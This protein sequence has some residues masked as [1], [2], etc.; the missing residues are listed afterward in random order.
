MEAVVT[1]STGSWYELRSLAGGGTTGEAGHP[2]IFKARLRGKLRLGGSRS[3]NPVV[4][5][6]NVVCSVDDSTPGGEVWIEEI[7][8]RRN[9]IIR[10]SSN[11]SRESHIIAANIDRALVVATLFS[12]VTSPEFIDR[13][14]VT[15]EAYGIP[16][17]I[18]LNKMDLAM[19]EAPE[20]VERFTEI[21]TGAGYPVIHA[22]AVTGQGVD[23]VRELLKGRTTLVSGNS[24]VGKSTLIKAVSPGLDIRIG[25]VS[26]SHGKGM[27]TTTFSQMY[28]LDFREKQADAALRS[29]PDLGCTMSTILGQ[30]HSQALHIPAFDENSSEGED[31]G[32]YIIDTPGI[33]GFG[34]IDIS[35][36]ELSR[37]FPDLMR[38]SPGCGY[39]NCTHTHEPECAVI[40]AV[41]EG[42]IAGERYISYLKMLEQDGKYRS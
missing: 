28:P 17:T 18:L 38:F 24:G 4:V 21:Y 27:H 37:Y 30:A 42:K 9:Y 25:E 14:L 40:R 6:D 35:P 23:E 3:T 29:A 31:V 20:A 33:K 10:R 13:F 32:G 16:A 19:A 7:L 11:L 8:P 39:Y 26:R 41:E 36:A 12:P 1:R 2:Q 15:C 5:G 22:S 34:L